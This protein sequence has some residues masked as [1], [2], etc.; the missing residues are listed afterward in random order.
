M[1]NFS[2]TDNWNNWFQMFPSMQVDNQS[3]HCNPTYSFQECRFVQQHMHP[4]FYHSCCRC[5]SI[6]GS[7]NQYNRQD[8]LYGTDMLK[9]NNI[10]IFML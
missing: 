7:H 9:R 8:S 1:G 6:Y 4:G 3:R 10:Y 5:R 2:D